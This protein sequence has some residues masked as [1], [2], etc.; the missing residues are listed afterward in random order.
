M[1]TTHTAPTQ[2]GSTQTYTV[3]LYFDPKEPKMLEEFDSREGGKI[4]CISR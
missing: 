4:G 1:T 2:V 3:D